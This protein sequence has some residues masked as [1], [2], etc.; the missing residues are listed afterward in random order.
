MRWKCSSNDPIRSGKKPK[1]TN[2]SC[3]RH[4]PMHFAARLSLEG[5]S[6]GE[7]TSRS[8]MTSVRFSS[9]ASAGRG[10]REGGN[11]L[12]D[13]AKLVRLH[14][15]DQARIFDEILDKASGNIAE[16]LSLLVRPTGLE[17]VL[18]P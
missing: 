16:L 9:P 6:E 5:R 11:L 10:V 14:N 13:E 7:T 2:T 12:R 18:P 15:R 8:R 1:V 3:W 4:L 17:P